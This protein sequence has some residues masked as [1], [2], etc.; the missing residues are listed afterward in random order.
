MAVMCGLIL[1]ASM[2]QAQ[3][4]DAA[5]GEAVHPERF[6]RLGAP[7]HRNAIY[8]HL[9]G[10]DATGQPRYYQAFRGTPWFLLS[11][12]PQTGACK[13]YTAT[14][15]DGNPWG[16]IWARNDKLYLTTG[17]GGTDD[18]FVFDPKTETLEFLGRATE[19]EDV[20]WSLSEGENGYLYGG[21]YPNAKLIRIDT[22]THALSDLGRISPDQMYIRNLTTQGPYVYC[23]AGPSLPAVWAY[24][25]RTGETTQI[26]NDELRSRSV[27]RWGT[28]EK[29]ADGK[30]YVYVPGKDHGYR[31]EGITLAQRVEPVPAKVHENYQG[32][33]ERDHITLDDGTMIWVDA[34]SGPEG[35]Y[36][37]GKPGQTSQR[38]PIQY[39]GTSTPLWSVEEG[40]DGAI[41]GTTRSPITLF[42]LMPGRSSAANDVEILGDPM[43]SKGQVYS[44]TWHRGRLY[45]ASYGGSRLTVWDPSRPWHF[46]NTLD[47]N[48]RYLGSS[49][50][51]RP[52]SLI[53][54]PDG[55]HLLVGGLP[56]YGSTGGVLTILNPGVPSTEVLEGLFGQQSIASM[57]T[58]PGSDL[59]C[60]G[61]TWRG[62]SASEAVAS[63]PRII[64]WNFR[65]RQIEFEVDA[66]PDPAAIEQMVL[67]NGLIYCTTSFDQGHLVVFDPKARSV[68][69]TAPLGYGPGTLFGVRLR[70]ADGMIY[71]ISGQSIVRIDP[72]TYAIERLGAYPC[73]RYGMAMAGTSIYF[74]AD[75]E[76]VRF[77]I[78]HAD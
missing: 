58:L 35:Y 50:I 73:M 34:N 11:I 22:R 31:V 14:G 75:D 76:L 5:A 1:G 27:S 6:T 28:A 33:P 9:L 72:A 64:L 30:V 40:P 60:I 49:H 8:N 44:W 23:N 66:L 38:L 68:L 51:G 17:G 29:R 20:I 32:N 54:A 16:M 56:S 4:S 2:A 13:Q 36:Y 18:V 10:K 69:H 7:V 19:T 62:G 39:K 45:M 25:T 46:G 26:L 65:T 67:V 77:D 63:Q 15:H 71:A 24:D 43:G 70:E 42:K 12:D 21:T 53:V 48:P 59:V 37:R 47:S 57:V 3:V 61:T 52:G 74:C 41:Y 55:E 78:P